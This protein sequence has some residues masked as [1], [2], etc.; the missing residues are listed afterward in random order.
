M[1]KITFLLM[2]FAVTLGYAQAPTG[3][4]PT[5]PAR[6]AVDVISVFTQTADATTSVYSDI[7]VANFN[8]NWGSTSGNVTIDPQGGDRA[9]TYPNFD[10]QGLIIGTNINVSSMTK[11]HVDIWTNSV[12]PNVYLISDSSG[13]KFINVPA[14]PN[15]WTSVEIDLTAFT[16]QGLSLNDIKE[17]KFATDTGASGVS[18]YIDNLYFSRPAVDPVTDAT[19]SDLQ[20]DGT[21][22]NAFG[23]G[24]T[25]YSFEVPPGTTVVPQITMATTTNASATAVITQA[26]ALPGAATVVVTAADMTTTETYTVNM[27]A[28]GPP[29]AAPI[30]PNRAPEDVISI[31]SDA[32]ANIGVDTFDTTWCNGVTTDESIGGNAMKKIT[33]L[34]CEGIDWQSSRTIDATGFTF[35]HIDIF[36]ESETLDK[37]FNVKFSNWGGTTGETSA[38]EFSTTNASTPALPSANPGTWISLDIP[39]AAWTPI[40]GA[41]ISDIVQFIITSDLGTVYYD[42]LYLHKNTVLS[43]DEFELANVSVFPNPSNSVWNVKSNDQNI[44]TVQVFDILGKEVINLSPNTIEVAIDASKLVNGIYLAKISS[45]KGTKTVKLVKN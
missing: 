1:K 12:T 24:T 32:Y 38:I 39:L 44:T 18:I 14:T 6:D 33:G 35:L 7:T 37:S 16:S 15:Q 30:P 9:L 2:L 42:N 26:T 22:I 40:N 34:G 3:A 5:P 17:F 10:Y 8:P 28:V 11:L 41:N 4:A 45:N 13:E 19:L 23:P 20:I 29:T 21:T 36:T 25:D 31:F 27:A 43:T